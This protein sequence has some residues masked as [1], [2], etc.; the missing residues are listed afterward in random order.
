M[1]RLDNWKLRI[2]C[3]FRI[4]VCCT[5]LHCLA[6]CCTVLHC[7]AL[8]CTMLHCV[9]VALCCTVLH[10][11]ALC[12]T[13]LHSVALCCTLLH[14][15]ALCCTVLNRVVCCRSIRVPPLSNPTPN[16]HVTNSISHLNLTNPISLQQDFS[17]CVFPHEDWGTWHS[18]T[19]PKP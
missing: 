5:V 15:V 1:R 10:C 8:C 9:G 7:V 3:P 17:Q 4:A 11:V 18:H 13:L 6:Q 16:P 14:C 19:N 2:G 12:C